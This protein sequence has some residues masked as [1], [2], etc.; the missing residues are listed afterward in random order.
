MQPERL[1]N[2]ASSRALSIDFNVY[3]DGNDDF[4]KELVVL[5]I[6]NLQEL[7]DILPVAFQQNDP[8]LFERVCHKIK[9]TLEM[10]EDQELLSTIGQLKVMFTDQINITKLDIVCTELMESLSKEL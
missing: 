2:A 3:T 10:L 4:K 9:P 5:I 7:K 8:L 1:F 6:E